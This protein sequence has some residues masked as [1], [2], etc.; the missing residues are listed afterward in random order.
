MAGRFLKQI[1]A[2]ILIAAVLFLTGQSDIYV[3]ER[4]G[5]ILRDHMEANYTVEDIL[6]IACKA[7]DKVSRMAVIT[8]G[9]P[10]DQRYK[11]SQTPVYAVAGGQ[12]TAVGEN[13]EI[14]KYIKIVHGDE[15]ESLYGNLKTIRV[16]VPFNVKKGQIIGIYEDT[17]DKEFYYSLNESRQ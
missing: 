8:Y 16:K 12:V 10:I 11:G 4:C 7:A 5:E 3:F 17:K 14:G 15:S 9:A 1:G 2:S 6:Q 13:E